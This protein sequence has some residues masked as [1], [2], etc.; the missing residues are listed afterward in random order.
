MTDS[1]KQKEVS[2]KTSL[3]PNLE[4]FNT[5]S[6]EN[7]IKDTN[8]NH[9]MSID[10]AQKA[11]SAYSD[12]QFESESWY[13]KTAQ[14]DKNNARYVN[15][16]NFHD[17][18]PYND[19][20]TITT[21]FWAVKMLIMR[22]SL[23]QIKQK[24]LKVR[25]FI[26]VAVHQ[27]ATSFDDYD[28][29]DI[30]SYYQE[31]FDNDFDGQTQL[32]SWHFLEHFFED[33]KCDKLLKLMKRYTVPKYSKKNKKHDEKYIPEE[34]A[35]QLDYL[36]MKDENIPVTYRCIY[37]TFR[38]FPNRIN[39]IASIPINALKQLSE[40]TYTFSIPS[41][42]QSGP[43][44]VPEIKII[45][46]KYTGMGKYFIDLVKET[47]KIARSFD[48]AS[49]EV[50]YLFTCPEYRYSAKKKKYHEYRENAHAMKRENISN[51]LKKYCKA[52]NIT[53]NNGNGYL[54]TSHQFRH[55][56]ISDRA[57]S[58]IFRD[59]D[60]MSLTGHHSRTMLDQAYE[61]TDKEKL[62]QKVHNIE[63]GHVN[64][65]APISF[66]GRIINTHEE[67]RY[68]RIMAKPFAKRI[69]NLGICSDIRNCDKD[70]F[71]CIDCP[72]LVPEI[73]DLDYIKHERKEW[74]QKLE[75]AEKL[76]MEYFAD[77]C[78][79]NIDRYDKLINR[80]LTAVSNFKMED[81]TNEKD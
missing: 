4:I 66:R 11:L 20:R 73:E 65:E 9:E 39:E 72:Y 59:I 32:E 52:N 44:A 36:Y 42:K 34:V 25:R 68:A 43:Y 7:F 37:W 47:E 45:F 62:A 61:H 58:G 13:I 5:P 41:F 24:V 48:S 27:N 12:D 53:D 49:F 21:K 16:I 2:P 67:Q 22:Q 6:K 60:I 15:T 14:K 75:K 63:N 46:I 1:I 78:R 40:D 28:A 23:S 51:F 57:N 81:L 8:I 71:A 50:E 70:R 74:C 17:F 77:N 35:D 54:I 69:H 76:G 80:I 26:N 3:A 30:L 19:E 38:L 29:K 10:E 18:P 56:A 33:I 64:V 31:C 55:N 79:F